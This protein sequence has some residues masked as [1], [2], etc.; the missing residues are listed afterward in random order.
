MISAS[1]PAPVIAEPKNTGCAR[2]SRAWAASARRNRSREIGAS[3]TYAASSV[4]SCSASTSARPG[5]RTGKGRK[6]ASRVPSAVTEPIGT[7]AGASLAAM[8]RSRSP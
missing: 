2:P 7:L 3:F 4:S 6:P 5:R 1:T 8:L